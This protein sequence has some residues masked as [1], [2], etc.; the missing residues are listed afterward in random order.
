MALASMKN[1]G[2]VFLMRFHSIAE[3]L[4]ALAGRWQD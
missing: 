2:A 1:R 4:S 3:P